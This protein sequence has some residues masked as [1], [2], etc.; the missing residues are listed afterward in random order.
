M[1]VKKRKDER[2]DRNLDKSHCIL[3]M[4]RRIGLNDREL[5]EED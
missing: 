1:N 3:I 5:A 2:T 4:S